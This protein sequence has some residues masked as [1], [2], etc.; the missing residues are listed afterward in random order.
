MD[1]IEVMEA[2]E[3]SGRMME[4]VEIVDSIVEMMKAFSKL[5]DEQPEFTLER[6]NANTA[7]ETLLILAD[8]IN[9]RGIQ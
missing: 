8:K 3:Y 4:R 9:K 5:R 1:V 2:A 6:I 7:I